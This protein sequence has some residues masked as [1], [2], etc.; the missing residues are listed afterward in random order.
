MPLK[1]APVPHLMALAMWALA[2]VASAAPGGDDAAAVHR[3][4]LTID[5]HLDTPTFL[6]RKGWDIGVRH[7]PQD[8]VAATGVGAGL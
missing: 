4:V 8:E 3:R 2:S 1:A 7:R 5:S 6:L